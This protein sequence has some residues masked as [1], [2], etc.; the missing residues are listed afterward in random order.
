MHKMIAGV[1]AGFLFFTACENTS[2]TIQPE[3]IPGDSM[4]VSYI[5]KQ[6]RKEPKNPALYSMRASLFFQNNQFEDALKDAL[7]A[8][9]LDTFKSE[10]YIQLSDYYI[11]AGQSENARNTLLRLTKNLP[12]YVPGFIA[13][14]KLHLYVK[15]FKNTAKWL[16]DAEYKDPEQSQIYFV[17]GVMLSETGQKDGAIKQF[18]LAVEKDPDL[19][20]AYNLLGIL[21]AEK[22]DTIAAQYYQTAA[23][24]Q[25]ES[26]DP[27]YNEAM[28]WQEEGQY[29]RAMTLYQQILAEK[30]SNY[31]YA[32]FNQGYILLNFL[33]RSADAIPLFEK[34]VEKKSGYVE[35][36]YNIGLCYE[37]MSK[38]SEARSYY[39]K[40]LEMHVNYPL[41]IEALNRLDKFNK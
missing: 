6:I 2:V 29:Q 18:R 11:A 16:A 40:A 28:L 19:Y 26:V 35:A 3:D 5:T 17:R 20:E 9:Q 13:M 10:Y 8:H 1:I 14:A 21:L 41:A 34:A 12:D 24:L 39:K 23:R 38:Y 32:Y 36:V 37:D 33:N 27:L 15:D 25:P 7:I 30:D 22:R 31:P 4:N